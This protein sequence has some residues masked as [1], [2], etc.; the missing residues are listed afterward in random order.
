[1]PVLD[2]LALVNP[3]LIGC[4]FY[5]VLS[6]PVL[7]EL[8]AHMMLPKAF[9]PKPLPH[10]EQNQLFA[11]EMPDNT[12]QPSISSGEVILVSKADSKAALSTGLFL[13]ETSTEIT[14]RRLKPN[15]AA[16]QIKVC[17]DSEQYD[18]ETLSKDEFK[19]STRVLGKVIG[20]MIK[21]VM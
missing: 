11:L 13:V 12:M 4:C 14:I 17:C 2:G 16:T 19:Q 18:D 5:W 15:V 1:M 8:V 3:V 20:T 7:D 10:T 9:L 6:M 21:A